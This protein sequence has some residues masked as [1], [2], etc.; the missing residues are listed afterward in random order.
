VACL[1][2]TQVSRYRFRHLAHLIKQP[3]QRKTVFVVVRLRDGKY[4]AGEWK[5][6][7]RTFTSRK[8]V[9]YL[10]GRRESA[11]SAVEQCGWKGVEVRE[12]SRV[13]FARLPRKRVI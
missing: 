10:W 5:W 8:H 2:S 1:V 4:W 11:Q 3:Q 13:E 12:V 7:G 6:R 9:A